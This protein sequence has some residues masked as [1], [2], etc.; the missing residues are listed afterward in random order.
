[1]EK[2]LYWIWEHFRTKELSVATEAPK[3]APL[4]D[5]TSR[6]VIEMALDTESKDSYRR[7]AELWVENSLS[8]DRV[9]E[10]LKRAP[11]VHNADKIES[12]KSFPLAQKS[13]TKEAAV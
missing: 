3:P 2:R 12:N 7:V 13:S 9:L 10:L 4:P 11:R 6:E 5:G 8:L 1:M